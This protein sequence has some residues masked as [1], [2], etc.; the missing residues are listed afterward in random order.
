MDDFADTISIERLVTMNDFQDTMIMEDL[1]DEPVHLLVARLAEDII[2]TGQAA[3]QH[4]QARPRST[5]QS[6]RDGSLHGLA[7]EVLGRERAKKWVG[8][9]DALEA[10]VLNAWLLR[11]ARSAKPVDFSEAAAAV[12]A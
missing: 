10:P 11:R 2:P 4:V 5:H 12:W 6:S 9:C 3:R 7:V 1:I 8:R